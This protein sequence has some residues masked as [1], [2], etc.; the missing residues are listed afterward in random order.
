MK[1]FLK[2][3]VVFGTGAAMAFWLISVFSL[4]EALPLVILNSVTLGVFWGHV[5]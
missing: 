2:Y 4:P 3:L 1:E 5:L